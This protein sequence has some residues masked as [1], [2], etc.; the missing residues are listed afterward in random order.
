VASGH[1]FFLIPTA[2]ARFFILPQQ[3]RRVDLFCRNSAGALRVGVLW[4]LLFLGLYGNTMLDIIFLF[5]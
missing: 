4:P 1:P 5:L 3:R 2:Q